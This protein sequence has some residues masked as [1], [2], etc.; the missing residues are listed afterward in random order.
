MKKGDDGCCRV[1]ARLKRECKR[2]LTKS[3]CGTDEGGNCQFCY[4]PCPGMF[5]R[6]KEGK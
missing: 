2:K 6:K 4:S 3:Y 1:C 5:E